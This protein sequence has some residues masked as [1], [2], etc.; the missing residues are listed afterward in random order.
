VGARRLAHWESGRF[1]LPERL[2]EAVPR[3]GEH[4]AMVVMHNNRGARSEVPFRQDVRRWG[5]LTIGTGLGNARFRNR[6]PA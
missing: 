6:A 1:K 4:E 5:V 3:I 2:R